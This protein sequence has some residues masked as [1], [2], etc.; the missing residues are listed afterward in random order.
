MSKTISYDVPTPQ[1]IIVRVPNW[2]GDLVMC[3]PTIHDLKAHWPQAKLTAL[4]QGRLGEMLSHDPHIDEI[5]TYKNPQHSNTLKTHK[6]VILHLQQHKYDLGLLLTNSFSS[7]W[8]FWRGNVANRIGYAM[9]W[10]QWLLNYPVTVSKNINQQHLVQTYK[11]LLAPLHIPISPTHPKLYLADNELE[12]AKTLLAKY[13]VLKSE[14]LIGINPGAAF[15]SAKC[16]LPERF[17]ELSLRLLQNPNIK[18]VFFGDQTNAALIQSIVQDLATTKIINLVNKTSLRQ[19]MS[20]LKQC[21]VFLGN[22]SGPTHAA[23]ALGVPLVALFGPTTEAISGPNRVNNIII[24]EH[25][26]CSPCFRRTC[27][28][29]SRCMQRITVERVYQAILQLLPS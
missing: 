28:I 2:L 29:D 14:Y 23:S 19:L 10:R 8:C 18:I 11:M 24:S 26:P 1:N 27:P 15:G 22:D 21:S 13:G 16:W 3:T 12:E 6:D 9:H 5:V 25:V 4:C 20:L 17:K 7:A